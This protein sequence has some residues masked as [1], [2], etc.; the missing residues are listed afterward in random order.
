MDSDNRLETVYHEP[1]NPS[2]DHAA[3]SAINAVFFSSTT[4]S[5]PKDKVERTVDQVVADAEPSVRDESVTSHSRK[6]HT[7]RVRRVRV[8][9]ATSRRFRPG[10]RIIQLAAHPDTQATHPS[11][12]QPTP[13]VEESTFRS[14]FHDVFG[15]ELL[16]AIEKSAKENVTTGNPLPSYIRD[17]FPALEDL[18]TAVN[19][20]NTLR[21]QFDLPLLV[22]TKQNR[23]EMIRSIARTR[24]TLYTTLFTALALPLAPVARKRD[25]GGE[26]DDEN[27]EKRVISLTPTNLEKLAKTL[28]KS[29]PRDKHTIKSFMANGGAG[30]YG[31]QDGEVVWEGG[32]GR[33]VS[34]E[35][36]FRSKTTWEGDVHVFV[37]Q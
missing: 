24:E 15:L 16:D 7:W 3:I 30:A 14:D 37:D 31:E 32:V 6:E 9:L 27:D 33:V 21:G 35:G 18:S 10:I 22:N 23:I 17:L 13:T 19:I 20:A 4:T 26:S 36:L 28:P 1:H 25:R 8:R 5:P 11:E 12:E 2:A 29:F 34:A